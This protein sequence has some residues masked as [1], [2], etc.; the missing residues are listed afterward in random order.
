MCPTTRR[1]DAMYNICRRQTICNVSWSCILWSSCICNFIFFLKQLRVLQSWIRWFDSSHARSFSGIQSPS[2]G[3]LV[4]R[5]LFQ[6][7]KSLEPKSLV[8]IKT[9]KFASERLTFVRSLDISLLSFEYV[10]V[11]SSY[12]RDYKTF[13]ISFSSLIEIYIKK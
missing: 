11:C 3:P 9:A 13:A 4:I 12:F 2:C 8:E 6:T 10:F 7:V 1:G 5:S